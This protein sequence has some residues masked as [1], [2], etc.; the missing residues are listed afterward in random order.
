M[1]IHELQQTQAL[2]SDPN[3]LIS[4]N[5]VLLS[6]QER[7]KPWEANATEHLDLDLCLHISTTKPTSFHMDFRERE[8]TYHESPSSCYEETERAVCCHLGLQTAGKCCQS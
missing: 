5:S 3:N 7:Q 8:V 2:S 6:T 4:M 1:P